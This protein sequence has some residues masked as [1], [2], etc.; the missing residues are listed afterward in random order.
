MPAQPCLGCRRPTTNGSRCPACASS[1]N[2]QRNQRHELVRQRIGRRARGYTRAWDRAAKQAITAQPFCSV[3]GTTG[4][5]DNPL[6]GDHLVPV[7]KGGTQA[8]GVAVLCRRDNS[9][10]GNRA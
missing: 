5:P 8:D 9:K 1:Y 4:T 7:S 6:T 3:C 2:A 10:R